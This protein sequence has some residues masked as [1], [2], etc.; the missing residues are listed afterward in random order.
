MPTFTLK[1]D[2]N[3]QGIR[4]DIYLV[5]AFPQLSSRTLAQHLIQDGQ[6][7]VNGHQEKNHYRVHRGDIIV[8][9]YQPKVP[10]GLFAEK[11]P[12][13]IFYEDSF[14]V[15]VNK[16]VG[17]TV[18][19]AARVSSGT[20]VNAL[21]AHCQSLSDVNQPFRPGIVHRLDKE[22]SGLLVVAKDNRTHVRLARQ[23]EKHRVRKQYL[24]I[25]KGEV[26][27]DEG[28]IEAP[29]GKHPRHHDKRAVTFVHAKGATTIYR[30]LHRGEGR[31]W[32]RLFPQ[33]GRTHQL[34]VH[35]AYIGH[36]I[37]GDAKYGDKDSFC[38]LALHAQALG[39]VHPQTNQYLECVTK[40]PAEL[41]I[42]TGNRPKIKD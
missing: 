17:M 37:L 20:L 10:Q 2:D 15:I 33:T 14:L 29:L 40:I 35:M 21:L 41:K 39:F 42:P 25:V 18:H 11:I 13:D 23:F 9:S 28:V 34:R 31:T 30:V 38:R 12:L 24:A 4:L 6:V 27:F 32:L 5:E 26:D 3:Y 19:P 8:V 7:K 22:T 1:V 16:P 36:P